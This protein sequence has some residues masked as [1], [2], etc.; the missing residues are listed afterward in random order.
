MSDNKILDFHEPGWKGLRYLI[1]LR[2]KKYRTNFLISIFFAIILFTYLIQCE[3]KYILD[4]V[5]NTVNI[6]LEFFP[7]L[8][9][10][11]LGGLAI[12]V[13]FSNTDLIR[14]ASNPNA[15]SVYQILNSNFTFVIILQVF[16]TSLAFFIK[17]FLSLNLE[18]PFISNSIC[19]II[20]SLVCACFLFLSVFLLLLTPTIAINL[21]TL[22][23]INN[24]FFT[25]KKIEDEKN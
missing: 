23:Q 8:L 14:K 3:N 24:M 15:I 20:N 18:F 25:I 22:S 12:V 10:F 16:I 5:L 7:S 6:N 11:S 9:G 17:W 1:F 2:R 19:I 13:G 4:F 21:F